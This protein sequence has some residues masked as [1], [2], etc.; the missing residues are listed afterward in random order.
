MLRCT[1]DKMLVKPGFEKLNQ[2][3]SKK[4]AQVLQLYFGIDM[5]RPMTLEEIGQKFHLTRERVRQIKERAIRILK[6][7]SN[8][9]KNLGK[10]LLV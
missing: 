10:Y 1:K 6:Q 2:S 8:V 9:K 4:E 7:K 3:L 5:E